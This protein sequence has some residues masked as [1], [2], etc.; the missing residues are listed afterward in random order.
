M[1]S[2]FALL[3]CL[4]EM[5]PNFIDIVKPVQELALF[6]VGIVLLCLEKEGMLCFPSCAVQHRVKGQSTHHYSHHL[7]HLLLC[8]LTTPRLFFGADLCLFSSKVDAKTVFPQ[9]TGNTLN[10]SAA[11]TCCKVGSLLPFLCHYRADGSCWNMF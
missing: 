3:F 8:I 6:Q 10:I 1:L 11:L 5:P 7:G 9:T 2:N 4:S